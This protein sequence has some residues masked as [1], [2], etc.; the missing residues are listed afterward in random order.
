MMRG[1]DEDGFPGDLHSMTPETTSFNQLHAK[2]VAGEISMKSRRDVLVM[3]H[4]K[5]VT[6]KTF[7]ALS[8]DIGQLVGSRGMKTRRRY[9]YSNK[10]KSDS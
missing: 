10:H 9:Y 8:K 7:E 4:S 1:K 3:D 2:K 5:V 6:P